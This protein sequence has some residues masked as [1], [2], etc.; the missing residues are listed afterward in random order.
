MGKAPLIFAMAFSPRSGEAKVSIDWNDFDRAETILNGVVLHE[1]ASRLKAL[2]FER[3]PAREWQDYPL[4]QAGHC[5]VQSG[6]SVR[7]I[8]K[9]QRVPGHVVERY[10]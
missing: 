9:P 1:P 2:T 10:N 6:A 8:A 5:A 3:F 4:R 7:C